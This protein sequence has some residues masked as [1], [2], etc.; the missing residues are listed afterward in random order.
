MKIA[1]FLSKQLPKNGGGY[2]FENKILE[3]VF[4]YAGDTHHQFVLYCA[5][6]QLSD[7]LFSIQP[8]NITVIYFQPNI[9]QD[10]Y[11]KIYRHTGA[12]IKK[13][14]HPQKPYLIESGFQKYVKESLSGNKIDLTWSFTPSC[15]T[16]ETPYITTVWDLQHRLQPYFPEVSVKGEWQKREET[17]GEMLQRATYIITGT[18]QGKKEIKEFYNISSER[19]KIF[20]FP[21]PEVSSIGGYKDTISVLQKYNIPSNYLF[22][23][24]QFWPHKNHMAILLA[25]KSLK[26]C[27]NLILPVVFTGSNQGNQEYIRDQ[28]KKLNLLDQVYFLGF[29]SQEDLI[30]LYTH[31]FALIFM[32]F[33]GPDNLPPLEA[34]C[35][36]CP[37]I[38]SDIPGA[39]EQLGNAALLARPND[40]QQIAESIKMLYEDPILRETLI[41]RGTMHS[42]KWQVKDYIGNML[43]LFDEFE[44]VR[45]CWKT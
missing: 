31:A 30:K 11:S 23:P 40:E 9:I 6:R 29:V 18:E 32:S 43:V 8:S 21:K 19:I 39:K 26:D 20:P 12:F 38:A 41:N 35:L 7:Q 37:V 14:T 34:F 44:C 33:F 36:N 15:P 16:M 45:R 3:G 10:L 2:T 28:V 25:V 42:S 13:I 1:I 17:F 4:K 24:A 22:Y 5:H 27:Y